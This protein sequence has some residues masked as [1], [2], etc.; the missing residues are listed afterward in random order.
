MGAHGRAFDLE[1]M[2]GVEE[3]VVGKDKLL[4]FTQEK[5]RRRNLSLTSSTRMNYKW[6]YDYYPSNKGNCNITTAL[7]HY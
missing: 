2:T 7:A 3:D 5:S 4:F 6:G 1:V